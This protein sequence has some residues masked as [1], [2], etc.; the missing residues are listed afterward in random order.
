[1]R[2]LVV[3]GGGRE[4]ALAWALHRDGPHSL[5]VCPGNPGTA[6]IA[7][8]VPG[9]PFQAALDT[10]SD[11]VVV[12]PEAPLAAGLGDRLRAAGI[13]CFGPGADCARLESSKWFAKEIMTAAGVPTARG[14][15]FRDRE[16][17]MDFMAGAPAEW[18]VKADGLAGGKGVVL[19]A[20]MEEARRAVDSLL[21]GA[22]GAVVVEERL[23]GPEV[24][25]MAVCSGD[26]AVIL[27]PSRDHKRIGEG[28]TGPNTGGMGAVCPPPGTGRDF[29]R[30]ALDTVFLPVLRELK[31][32]GMDYRG[33]LY[34]GMMLTPDGPRVLE[35]NVRFGDPEAQAVLPVIRGGLADLFMSAALGGGLSEPEAEPGAS[36]VVILASRGYP[37][38]CGTGMPITGLDRV[39]DVLLFHAGTS[40]RDGVLVTSGGRVMG[41]TALGENL[42]R[43]LELCYRA[44]ETVHFD[45]MTYRRDIGRSL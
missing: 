45:G 4:H 30:E 33:A 10:G 18:V 13:P 43:A 11:L 34:A 12:G 39:R 26:R 24:S 15:L 37:G 32:R 36:A 41:I 7:V 21:A 16:S 27:P 29:S 44:A 8:N 3:G 19:P 31:S 14:E 5:A 35:F 22:S 42:D 6:D 2:I 40:I 38:P 1:M 23:T 25:V 17:A 20:S 28:N 9:D